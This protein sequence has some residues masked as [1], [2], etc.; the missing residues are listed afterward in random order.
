MQG[1]GGGAAPNAA[2]LSP[3]T[4]RLQTGD[5]VSYVVLILAA[6]RVVSHTGFPHAGHWA[7]PWTRQEPQTSR[8]GSREV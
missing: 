2:S 1:E 3:H 7:G 5:S 6:N 4:L 8:N